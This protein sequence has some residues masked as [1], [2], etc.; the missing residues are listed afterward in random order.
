MP[1]GWRLCR[2]GA[3]RS[4]QP[5]LQVEQG[6]ARCVTWVVARVQEFGDAAL[7]WGGDQILQCLQLLVSG[8]GRASWQGDA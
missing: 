3:P 5:S 7:G 1:P 6:S 2:R 8:G 4:P